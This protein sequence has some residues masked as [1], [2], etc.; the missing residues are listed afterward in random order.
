MEIITEIIVQ[1]EDIDHL[2]HMN[3][4]KYLTYLE[5][6]VIEWY[7]KSGVGKEGLDKRNL[8]TVLIK[9]DVS[10]IHEAR[11][12]DKLRIMTNLT[13]VGNKSFVL[14]QDIY[15]ENQ[16]HLTDCKK[17]FVMFNLETRKGVPVIEEIAQQFSPADKTS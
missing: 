11:L 12:G 4:M 3:Y 2:G 14:K 17:T 7:A 5:K 15:N 1:Q 8:G 9:F 10:Y 13:Y 6:G 16:E